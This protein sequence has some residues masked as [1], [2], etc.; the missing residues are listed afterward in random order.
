MVYTLRSYEY[1]L[2]AYRRVWRGSVGATVL[3]P[4]LYLSALGVGLGSIVNRGEGLGVPT[5]TTSRRAS[6]PR[7]R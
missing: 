1:W 7:P 5:S 3:N 6:S 2:M 4:I